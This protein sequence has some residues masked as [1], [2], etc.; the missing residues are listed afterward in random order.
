MLLINAAVGT[1]S[2]VPS[3]DWD[4]PEKSPGFCHV[5]SRRLSLVGSFGA[6]FKVSDKLSESTIPLSIEFGT[7]STLDNWF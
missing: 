4:G 7:K 6:Y 5:I 3:G 1:W 2:S